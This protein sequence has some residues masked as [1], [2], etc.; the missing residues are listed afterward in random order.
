MKSFGILTILITFQATAAFLAPSSSRLPSASFNLHAAS[1]K[2]QSTRLGAM[3]M[4]EIGVG[5]I[6]AGRIGIVHLEALAGCPNAK[7]II[8]SNPTVSKAQDAA[9]KFNVPN[10]SDNDMDV[11][12]H[13]DVDAVWICSPSSFHADQIKA[14][15]A[16]GKHIFC[17]KPVATDLPETVE[18]INACKSAGVKLMTA[19]QRRFDP[20][21]SRVR[22]A[23]TDGEIG[24][25]VQVKLC[26]RDPAPPPFEYVKGGGGIF[27]DMA[28]HDLDMTRF[29]MGEEPEEILAIGS[30]LIDKSINVL[31]G[32]E[33]YDTAT[34]VVKYPGGKTATI[35]VCRQAPYGYDQRAEVL[36]LKGMIAT[37][38]MYPNTARIYTNE[39]TR[40]A[41]LP[42]DF[43]MSRYK[44][45]YLNETFAFVNALINDEPV[46]CSGEDGLIAL[47]MAIAAGISAEEGRWVR[48]DEVPVK[49]IK[50]DESGLHCEIIA[51]SDDGTVTAGDWAQTAIN[52]LNKDE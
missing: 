52:V 45:A 15:A 23:I 5:V 39:A 1:S 47:V 26:S 42:F 43:F 6:G 7:P 25:I 10:Y 38:N 30:T 9:K 20:N 46:P 21:F 4:K 27:K 11:I 18:A 33:A 44:E 12:N 3:T 19:L 51:D 37:D 13:P 2:S 22:Q 35:D 29:L 8:I 41:D 16:A 24:D 50:C 49:N 14:C 32:A 40:N 28:V 48:F 34:I 17:E 36:G 31:P